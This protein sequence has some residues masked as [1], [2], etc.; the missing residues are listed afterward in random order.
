MEK[1]H[2]NCECDEGMPY[3]V[4]ICARDTGRGSWIQC[5]SRMLRH[6]FT[7]VPRKNTMVCKSLRN[8]ISATN[9]APMPSGARLIQASNLPTKSPAG[10]RND[11][12]CFV[13]EALE[14]QTHLRRIPLTF[15]ILHQCQCDGL[16]IYCHIFVHRQARFVRQQQIR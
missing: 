15:G 14:P 1:K 5:F 9:P 12:N 13:W 7:S 10:T 3:S 8:S 16:P 4:Q 11:R 2:I 6:S